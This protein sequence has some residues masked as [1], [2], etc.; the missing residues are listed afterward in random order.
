MAET[1]G[2]LRAPAPRPGKRSER[3][4]RKRQRI[5][6]SAAQSFTTHGF[7]KTTVEEIASGASVSKGLVYAYF[8]GKEE[9]LEAVLERTLDEW[10]EVAWSAIERDAKGARDRLA[11]MH[12]ASLVFARDTPFLRT[13]L[14]PDSRVLLSEHE[15]TVNR[16]METFRLELVKMLEE[17]VRSGELRGDLDVQR[18]A[19]TIRVLHV[20]FILRLF[21]DGLIDVSDE[22]LVDASI[23]L[24]LRGVGGDGHRSRGRT[25]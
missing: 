13:L 10:H 17:G 23:E 8:G 12:R 24:M 21:D 9:L 16:T 18:T 15:G 11:I 2:D 25:G 1:S 6:D 5:L 7:A 4:E 14:A 3:V 19:D 22:A 20:A